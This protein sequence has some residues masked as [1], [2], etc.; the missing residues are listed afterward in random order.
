MSNLS[1]AQLDVLISIGIGEFQH[2]F[3][4]EAV[5]SHLHRMGY[6]VLTGIKYSITGHG[7]CALV[8]NG[9]LGPAENMIIQPPRRLLKGRL[10]GYSTIERAGGAQ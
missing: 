1:R 3:E 4:N 7:K 10:F 2:S 9:Y 6:I 8:V 5:I